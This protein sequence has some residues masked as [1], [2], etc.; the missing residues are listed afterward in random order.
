MG[1]K[2]KALCGKLWRLITFY[3]VISESTSL[4][5]ATDTLIQQIPLLKVGNLF[6]SHRSTIITLYNGAFDSSSALFLVIK[7]RNVYPSLLLVKSTAVLIHSHKWWSLCCLAFSCSC[8]MRL[9]SPFGPPSSFCLAA[10]SFTCSGLS[11][12][13][14]KNLFPTRCLSATHMGMISAILVQLQSTSGWWWIHLAV[15]VKQANNLFSY[16][17]STADF[18]TITPPVLHILLCF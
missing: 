14:Q 5:P 8:Y 11:S 1:R 18:Y 15:N 13:C 9:A 17:S 3:P 12:C 4:Y 10:A 6:G 2:S 16:S 7:V